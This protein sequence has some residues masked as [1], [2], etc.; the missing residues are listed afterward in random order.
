MPCRPATAADYA[1]FARLMPEL[2]TG[3]TV[4]AEQ[5]FARDLAPRTILLEDGGKV[6]GYA[7]FETFG[8]LGY[9]RHIVV[10]PEARGRGAG[11]ALMAE[12]ATRL[13]AA[14]C[15]RWCLN[16]KPDNRP[17]LKLYT[18]VGL[19]RAYESQALR[20]AWDNL[21]A[22]PLCERPLEAHVVEPGEDSALEAA[23]GLPAGSLSSW[24]GASDFVI[25]ALRDAG[26]PYLARLGVCRFSPSFP[27]AAPFRV[28]SPELARPLLAG[29][30]RYALPAHTEVQLLVED[31]PALTRAL[32]AAGAYVRLEIVHMEG[33]L[34]TSPL[35]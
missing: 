15:T 10:A 3:D 20:L 30:R 26:A 14:G 28:S 27:G 6:I 22:L 17:A 7:Y 13:R 35:G 23:F 5:V 34:P 29:M 31:D 32:L 18:G 11:R 4:P 21:P 24:R 2:A 12:V 19:G 25:L 9:V 8:A 16:V 33:A 1:H